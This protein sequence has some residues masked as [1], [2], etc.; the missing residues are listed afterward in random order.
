MKTFRTALLA[1]VVMI[2]GAARAASAKTVRAA[3]MSPSMWAHLAKGRLGEI[4][5][6]FRQGDELPLRFEAQGDLIETRQP[7]ATSA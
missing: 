2:S 4:I 1:S 6:E 7:S 5:V 3:E